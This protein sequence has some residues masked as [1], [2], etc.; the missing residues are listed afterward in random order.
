[1]VS[2]L[3]A[4][5]ITTEKRLKT[6][7]NYVGGWDLEDPTHPIVKARKHLEALQK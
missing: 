3:L 6:L 4:E 1:V 2:Q 5:R 7:L